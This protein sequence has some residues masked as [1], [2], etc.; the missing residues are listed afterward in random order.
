VRLLSDSETPAD[1]D[2]EQQ[3][4][5]M[6]EIGGQVYS[7]PQLRVHVLKSS[8][9]VNW[10]RAISAPLVRVKTH[11]PAHTNYR[12]F[13]VQTNGAWAR[14]GIAGELKD[15]IDDDVGRTVD[16]LPDKIEVDT[17]LRTQ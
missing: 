13:L 17:E 12:T 15:R 11:E 8:H 6:G 9:A 5:A 3:P 1:F 7:Q 2:F 4:R 14:L 16:E 10:S